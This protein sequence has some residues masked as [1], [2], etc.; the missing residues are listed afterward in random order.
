M[1]VI[2]AVLTTSALFF[3]WPATAVPRHADAIVVLN[4]GG[5]RLQEGVALASAGVAPW[6]VVSVSSTGWLCPPP[7]PHVHIDCFEPHPATT[8]GEA[9]FAG[10]LARQHHWRRMVVVASTPQVSRARLRVERCYSGTI[11][12]VGVSPGGIGRWLYGIVYEWGA[13]FKAIVLQPSC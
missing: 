8:Q 9:R 10:K 7:I 6:L 11:D 5:P 12:M 13:S 1:A 2:I 3:V 4:G